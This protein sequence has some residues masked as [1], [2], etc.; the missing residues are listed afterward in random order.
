MLDLLIQGG[1]VVDGSGRPPRAADVGIRDGRIVSVDATG[2][3]G[4]EPARQKLDATGLMV[5]PGFVDL[6]THYDAQL[7]WDPSASPSP[8]HG[9][10]T[11]VGGNCGFSLAP[12]GPDHADYIMRLMAR[13]EGMPLA[14]LASGPSWDWE[15]FSD[16]LATLDGKVGVNAGFLVGHSA[17]RRAVMGTAASAEPATAAQAEG[18]VRLL[19]ESLS[20]GALGF[21][22]SRAPTH[23]D[24]D[25]VPVPS[26]WAETSEILA[27]ASA[28]GDHPGTTLEFILP[29]CLSGFSD[30]EIGFMSDF[31]LAAGRP[32]N[33]NVLGVS[34]ANPES[35]VRQLD[36][37]TRASERGARIVALTLPHSMGIRLSF[38][39]G[40]VLDG[41]P[42]WR[43][44][45]SLPPDEKRRALADPAVRKQLA[46][47]A[48]SPEAGVLGM[49]ATW[50]R[51][52]IAET[53]S[54]ANAGL[55]GRPVGQIAKERGVDAFDALLDVVIEDDL[56]TGI[57]PPSM[58]PSAE[59]W[60]LR[61]EVWRDPRAVVG[62][63]DAGAHLDMMCGAVY[64]TSLLE[65][66]RE[67][68]TVSWEEAAQ[69]LAD[70]PARLYG[71]RERG[72]LE[73]G[74]H[75][76][77][78]I[79]DPDRV[80]PGPEQTVDDLPGGASR[81]YADADGIDHVLVNGTA[82]VRDGKLTG[83][84]PGFVLRSGR[85]TETVAL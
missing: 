82:V 43:P 13:V 20:A 56:R 37:S 61:A 38:L 73:P 62:G 45:M 47:G 39:S 5:A 11:V 71:L 10:T 1:T 51:L 79:F 21:S 3:N 9:V 31:S 16:W 52:E 28:V 78:T 69:L 77:V 35:H 64:S 72:R 70:V 17:L 60:K 55:A 57:R 6:H 75:A 83:A 24:G 68:G 50:H 18:M 63:S 23:N 29:G 12:A 26:R 53:F 42:G 65:S 44:V 4:A 54:P 67:H 49:L 59:D 19:H 74:F 58:Q 2:G 85:D 25:G 81:L 32:A 80:G 41:L 14:A 30:E 27:L 7:A 48:A 15:S 33:W 46:D 34:S 76:D 40:A 66:V 84:I 22:T 36:A 8:L